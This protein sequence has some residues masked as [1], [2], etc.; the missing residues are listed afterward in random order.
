VNT[1]ASLMV[2]F[3]RSLKQS[4]NSVGKVAKIRLESIGGSGM[5][6]RERLEG[7][8]YLGVDLES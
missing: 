3:S 4:K 2:F 5:I 1:N 8:V 7:I 6:A